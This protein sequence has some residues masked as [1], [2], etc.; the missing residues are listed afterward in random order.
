MKG[1]KTTLVPKLRFPKFRATE[2]WRAKA[3]V[4]L[5]TKRAHGREIDGLSAYE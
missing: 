2:V 4:P 1:S 5:L 3:L